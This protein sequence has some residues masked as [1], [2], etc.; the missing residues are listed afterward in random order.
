MYSH[1]QFNVKTSLSSRHVNRYRVIRLGDL[2]VFGR[3][4]KGHDELKAEWWL[5]G[6]LKYLY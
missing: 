4:I 1:L 3:Q 5:L 6:L 2:T